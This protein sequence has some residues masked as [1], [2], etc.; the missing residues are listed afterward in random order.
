MIVSLF[1]ALLAKPIKSVCKAHMGS[2][3]FSPAP[4]SPSWFKECMRQSLELR[5]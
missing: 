1:S 2:V 5:R 3:R 4:R